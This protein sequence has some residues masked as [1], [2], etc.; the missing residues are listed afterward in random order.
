MTG[1]KPQIVLASTS[2]YRRQLLEK[3]AIPFQQVDPDY[4]EFAV[5]GES[6]PDKALR[7]ARGKAAAAAQEWN[8]ETEALI[9]GSDQ[10][11][12]CEA[13]VFSKPGGF[14]RAMQQL[15]HCS[16]KWTTF[17]TAV[18][19][20]NEKGEELDSFIDE[21]HLKFRQLSSDDIERYLELDQPY[22]CAGSI[23]AESHGILLIEAT[24]GLDVNALYGLPLI[25]LTT[26]LN[27]LGALP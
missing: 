4:Q 22:D 16:G 2:L 25:K 10:V 15:Q 5:E 3:L 14:H 19:L 6:P 20:Y 12:H 11:A 24:K 21:Y 1:Q 17:S 18:S 27:H 8:P 9:I 7:L 26:S 13:K 23:K